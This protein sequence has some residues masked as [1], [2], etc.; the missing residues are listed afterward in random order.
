MNVLGL[1]TSCDETAAAVYNENGLRSN[2]VTSQVI[3]FAYGGV[4]PELASREHIRLIIPIVKKSLDDAKMTLKQ[5]D[6][7]AVTHG[8]GLVGSLLV[9]LNFA[10]ALSMALKIPFIGINHIEGHIFANLIDTQELTPPFICLIISGGHT[11]LVLIEEFGRYRTLGRTRDDAAGEAFD[12]VAKMLNIGYPG[13]PIIDALSR[14]ANQNFITF[15]RP[16]LRE[17]NYDFSFSGIKTAVLY[18]I[19][20]LEPREREAQIKDIAASFQ[21]ALVEVLVTKAIAAAQDYGVQSIALAGG[22]ASN[23]Y[24]RDFIRLKIEKTSLRLFIPSPV[25]C[26]DNAAMISRA[27][28]FYLNNGASSPLNLSP[29]PSLKLNTI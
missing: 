1:E 27:G 13:G 14:G 15:P 12:K 28:Y 6:G 3:H 9:G 19:R 25:Y 21:A 29:K 24:L 23:L 5:I 16:M 8:P 11:Q 17:D 18:Y 4:V 26:T 7:I 10:K 20:K 2:V 22:V